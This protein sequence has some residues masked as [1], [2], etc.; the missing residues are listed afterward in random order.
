MVKTELYL[1]NT[2]NTIN[3][4][5]GFLSRFNELGIYNQNEIEIEVL[6]N[7]VIDNDEILEVSALPKERFIYSKDNDLVQEKTLKRYE[8][9]QIPNSQSFKNAIKSTGQLNLILIKQ[10]EN[11]IFFKIFSCT[12]SIVKINNGIKILTVLHPYQNL[13]KEETDP[14]ELIAV[15]N[16]ERIDAHLTFMG[17]LNKI[18][19]E[20][21]TLES[22]FELL[23]DD[24]KD[25]KTKFICKFNSM[26]N[27]KF[28][29]LRRNIILD[30]FHVKKEQNI[31]LDPEYFLQPL[32]SLDALLLDIDKNFKSYL[33][34]HQI[35]GIEM[36]NDNE[37]NFDHDYFAIGY[38]DVVGFFKDENYSETVTLSFPLQMCKFVH[39]NKSASIVKLKKDNNFMF[40]SISSLLKGSSGAPI[41]SKDGKIVG[42][43]FG[44]YSD[45]TAYEKIKRS[46]DLLLFDKNVKEEEK[47][48]YMKSKN[49]NLAISINHIVFLE[50]NILKK[51]SNFN[52]IKF[53]K[54]KYKKNAYDNIKRN[55]KIVELDKITIKGEAND[56]DQWKFEHH[57]YSDEK[58]LL[59]KKYLRTPKKT[60]NCYSESKENI[61]N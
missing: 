45:N 10:V 33:A 57:N 26:I 15:F 16:F 51:N 21:K 60:R 13:I 37:V 42:M 30:N 14:F 53:N 36:F 1:N 20:S 46:Q 5:I 7:Y 28:F 9:K 58:K 55:G 6:P 50:F 31:L 41:L 29:D 56:I 32:P 49:S 11:E 54:K 61:N 24:I 43:S 19:N 34:D 48:S 23:K 38:N 4:K 22:T 40:T 27:Q 47:S 39:R 3:T 35:L 17:K 25:D 18:Q 59:G 12:F 52:E 8:V 2:V 44:Y